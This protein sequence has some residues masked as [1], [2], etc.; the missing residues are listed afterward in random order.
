MEERGLSA[1]WQEMPAQ[2]NP[3][4]AKAAK[5]GHLQSKSL[6]SR[7]MQADCGISKLKLYPGSPDG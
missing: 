1:G 6:Q 3:G 7:L 4:L 2:T 5:L